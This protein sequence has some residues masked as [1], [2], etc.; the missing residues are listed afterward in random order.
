MG[1]IILVLFSVQL[2]NCMQL[3]AQPAFHYYS[4]V[5]Y[6]EKYK[7]EAIEQMIEHGIPASITMA[8]ALLESDDGN[9]PLAKFAN[10]HFGIKCHLDWNGPNFSYDDD[11]KGEC[12]RKYMDA[13]NSYEDHSLFLKSRR[14]YAPL[15]QL[16]SNDYR[17]WAYGLKRAGYA[18]EPKY[19]ELLIDIIEKNQLYKLDFRTYMPGKNPVFY[20]STK[21]ISI[22]NYLQPI[23]FCN[24]I[25]YI[26]S[27]GNLSLN[28]ISKRYNISLDHLTHYNDVNKDTLF[29]RGT[30]IFLEPKRNESIREFYIASEGETMHSISQ[31]FGLRLRKL[32]EY[33]RMNKGAEPS[34]GQRIFLNYKKPE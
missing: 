34:E 7:T 31:H 24:N 14:W 8:Q 4:R 6:I 12:F 33:N 21:D 5:E 23:L 30:K 9:S 1:K 26:E 16:K 2:L 3:L 17:G 27:N 29:L 19:A 10:N 20:A 28:E 25:K 13:I 22:S 11:A 32:L 15:F 18:T